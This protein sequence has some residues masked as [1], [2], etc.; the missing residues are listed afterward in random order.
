MKM[1]Y[2]SAAVLSAALV[3]TGC[4]TGGGDGGGTA[5]TD[6]VVAVSGEIRTLDPAQ[7]STAFTSGGDRATAIYGSLMKYDEDGGVVAAMAESL[8]S[9]DLTVWTLQ[10]RDGVKFTDGT[11]YDAEAVLFN[12][13]RHRADDSTSPAKALLN[14]VKSMEIVD[15]LTIEFTLAQPS[16]SFPSLLTNNTTLGYI[17][18]PTAFEAD[19]EGF[20]AKPVGAGPFAIQEWVRDSHK[21]GRA[22]V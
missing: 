22:H 9:P 15:P 6:A 13:E 18:S 2:F 4:S 16:G 17:V 8:E 19:P 21:I 1:Q 12:L 5:R 3:L 20:G 7:L 10:L 14:G 11:A